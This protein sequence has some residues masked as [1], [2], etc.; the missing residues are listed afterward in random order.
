MRVLIVGG[1]LAGLAAALGI[2]SKS[3]D[4]EDPLDLEVVIVERRP[5]FE[6]RGATFGLQPNGIA[7]LEE[8]APAAL[9][10]MREAGISIA[11]TGGYMLP[12]WTVRDALLDAVLARKDR[13]ALR[14]GMSI[15]SVVP[16]ED[17]DGRRMVA[18]FHDSDVT[19]EADVIVGADGVHSH[20]RRRIL[21]LPPA[22]PS[23]AL[24]WR[25]NVDTNANT[26]LGRFKPYPLA[27]IVRFGPA[28]ILAYF[29][30]QEKVDGKLAWVF[31]LN[32]DAY[33]GG[34]D[35]SF[36]SGATTPLDLIESYVKSAESP[37]DDVLRKDFED[38]KL[39]LGSTHLPSD[40]TYSTE[41]GVVDLNREHGWGGRGNVTLIG[42][43][44]H[45][46][47]PASGLGGSLAFEDATLL[48]RAIAAAA[49]GRDATGAGNT[50]VEGELRSFEARRLPRCR[51]LSRDQ[52]IRS[53][54]SY[55][56]PFSD[57][58]PCDPKYREWTFKGP[59]ASPEPPVCETEVFGS[60]LEKI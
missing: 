14:M 17:G 15:K 10:T 1:G 56:I 26:S 41:M 19:I 57:I 12:W 37:D 28:L 13:I 42:D 21:N 50:S 60:L 2:A 5:D 4:G 23:N 58:P 44:A 52:T 55:T 24:V 45:S 31:T 43:A 49:R 32:K 11:T 9:E 59:D 34:S 36:E 7:A 51:S 18:T 20:V 40:L 30:F 3:D 6:S 16:S 39:V 22:V 53:K 38:A 54:L 48:S 25:G 47:R 29:N 33:A 8:I 46:L 35:P 27:T